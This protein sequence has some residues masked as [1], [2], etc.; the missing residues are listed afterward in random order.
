[1]VT[2]TIALDDINEGFRAMKDGEVI[3]SVI[4]NS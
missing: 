2:K 4:V 3:R 1:M